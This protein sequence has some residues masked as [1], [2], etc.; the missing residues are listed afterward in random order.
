MRSDPTNMNVMGYACRRHAS[1]PMKEWARQGS[2]S[3]ILRCAQ[4][5]ILIDRSGC[6]E[7]MRTTRSSGRPRPLRSRFRSKHV[8]AEPLNAGVPGVA[9]ILPV[10]AVT[11]AEAPIAGHQLDVHHVFRHLVTELKSQPQS[12]GSPVGNW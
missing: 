8:S 2:P 9:L 3:C 12:N 5:T 11:P 7:R 4:E 6:A 10:A 1:R